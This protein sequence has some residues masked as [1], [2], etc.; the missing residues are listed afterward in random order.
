MDVGK[1]REQDAEALQ[2]RQRTPAMA[3]PMPIYNGPAYLANNKQK[4]QL[5]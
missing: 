1:G 4:H 2:A 5:K 3:K